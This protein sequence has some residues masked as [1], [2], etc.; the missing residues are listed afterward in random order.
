MSI[1]YHIRQ[2]FGKK[3]YQSDS[4]A[5]N[6]PS[7]LKHFVQIT[8]GSVRGHSRWYK[9]IYCTICTLINSTL[10]SVFYLSYNEKQINY[11]ADELCDI[12]LTKYLI[13]RKK[14]I[15][16]LILYSDWQRG[17]AHNKKILEMV[18]LTT[19]HRLK[20]IYWLIIV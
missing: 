5:L 4:Q 2:Q 19:L 3:A 8:L 20:D 6:I 1:L 18:Y 16:N 12:V 15:I 17:R 7:T 14:Y 11:L 10:M 13:L 9:Q